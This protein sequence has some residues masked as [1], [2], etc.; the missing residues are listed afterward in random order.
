MCFEYSKDTLVTRKTHHYKCM[1]V[2]EKLMKKSTYDIYI[3]QSPCFK[4]YC[5][6]ATACNLYM[7][8]NYDSYIV[9]YFVA[10]VLYEMKN[11][12]GLAIINKYYDSYL[13][14]EMF[15]QSCI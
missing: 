9:E 1:Y 8:F 13:M 11:I 6:N 2:Q 4:L 12:D 3:V 14:C 15:L 10:Q 7:F 5:K